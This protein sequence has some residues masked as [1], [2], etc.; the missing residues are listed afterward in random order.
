LLNTAKLERNQIKIT[1]SMYY[2]LIIAK[3]V[4]S[5]LK[6]DLANI[7][8]LGIREIMR[9]TNVLPISS[10]EITRLSRMEYVFLIVDQTRRSQIM[11]K[12]VLKL[13]KSK[14]SQNNNQKVSLKKSLSSNQL[15]NQSKNLYKNQKR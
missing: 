3:K 2:H 4:R 7:A 15:K 5:S 11:E 14:K 8:P 10:V 13:K 1:I 6:M 9:Q 12:A